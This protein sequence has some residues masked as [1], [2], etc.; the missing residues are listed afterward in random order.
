MLL[1]GSAHKYTGERHDDHV[2]IGRIGSDHL[3]AL[4][5][6]PRTSNAKDA[7][8][9]SDP[10]ATRAEH[11]SKAENLCSERQALRSA[12]WQVK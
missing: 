4:V 1:L 8:S 3:Y 2:A 5:R 12:L 6:V 10:L 9:A 7:S 11:L